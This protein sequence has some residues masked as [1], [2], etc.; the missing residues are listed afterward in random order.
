MSE[1]AT[2]VVFSLEKIVR[3]SLRRLRLT[4][5]PRGGVELQECLAEVLAQLEDGG[6]VAAPAER[7]LE[8]V[9]RVIWSTLQRS[10]GSNSLIII[11]IFSFYFDGL[12]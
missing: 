9:T 7:R 3:C 11:I 5:S 4:P 12:P 8:R 2:N 1:L 10:E 6:H